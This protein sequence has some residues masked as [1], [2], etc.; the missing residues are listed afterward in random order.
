MARVMRTIGSRKTLVAA[1]AVAGITA[2]AAVLLLTRP[3][4]DGRGLVTVVDQ[5]FSVVAG[6]KLTYAFI[7]ENKSTSRALEGARYEVRFFGEDGRLLADRDG[8]LPAV[9]PGHRAAIAEES[10]EVAGTP[11][12]MTVSI[13]DGRMRSADGLPLLR[14]AAR[15]QSHG[16]PTAGGPAD[17]SANIWNPFATDLID[18][19]LAMVL[20]NT[21][22]RILG[23]GARLVER[24]QPGYQTEQIVL[25]NAPART[26]VEQNGSRVSYPNRGVFYAAPRGQTVSELVAAHKAGESRPPPPPPAVRWA[27]ARPPL[28]TGPEE[29]SAYPTAGGIPASQVY[30]VD[31]DSEPRLLYETGRW[32]YSLNWR[33][34]A[35]ALSLEFRSKKVDPPP[36]MRGPYY[37]GALRG[38][39]GLDTTNGARL[40]EAMSDANQTFVPSPVD[41]LILYEPSDRE[42]Y[43]LN[44]DGTAL[45]LEGIG[46]KVVFVDWSP[47]GDSILVF[48]YE[49]VTNPTPVDGVF[50]VVPVADG[51]AQ[52]LD[53]PA[54]HFQ[55]ETAAWSP[56]GAKVAFVA[57]VRPG[58]FE[59]WRAEGDLYVYDIAAK[60]TQR[61]TSGRGYGSTRPAWSANGTRLT[62]E[63]DLIEVNSG[64]VVSFKQPPLYAAGR[65]LSPDGRYF[66]VNEV[67]YI[68]GPAGCPQDTL[69]NRTYVYD[70]TT[71][72]RRLLLDCD[73]GYYDVPSWDPAWQRGGGWVNASRSLV[74]ASPNC[75]GS[76]CSTG[77]LTLVDAETGSTRTLAERP[78]GGLRAAASPDG[79]KLLVTGDFI[80]VLDEH[81]D[82]LR[83]ISVPWGY[84]VQDA[85]W[86][87]DGSKVA[88]VIVPI[89][90]FEGV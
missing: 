62:I 50:Y 36:E 4:D 28:Y 24:L 31:G 56:D 20:F 89:G 82:V 66:I 78:Q 33:P 39:L 65:T 37:I 40:W 13:V 54:D 52:R 87:P 9:L 69:R 88:Y 43:I 60:E 3:S 25:E 5:G 61:L 42:M 22:G 49:R 23:G 70:T 83:T 51:P 18:V 35:I 44:P 45:K 77:K 21:E 86:S 76:P 46:D 79:W 53:P 68:D 57:G 63:G 73:R 71:E 29:S 10:I 84:E 41:D 72:E 11:G 30:V 19:Y 15:T 7:A 2:I 80:Q 85:A 90:M 38:M 27:P 67:G 59:S 64:V 48:S 14:P 26:V 55:R 32:V 6:S 75:L 81:G 16:P 17:A 47:K 8:A 74:L 1:T 12:E 58:P 34:G